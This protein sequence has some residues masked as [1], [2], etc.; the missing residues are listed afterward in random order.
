[1][2]LKGVEF[3][4]GERGHQARSETTSSSARAESVMPG[5]GETVETMTLPN[6]ET[7]T[8]Y[9]TVVVLI[10]I[11]EETQPVLTRLGNELAGVD[12][13]SFLSLRSWTIPRLM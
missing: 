8:R 10:A 5:L 4:R 12:R 3:Q 11:I 13:F 6:G 9:V 7:S 2:E 1:M